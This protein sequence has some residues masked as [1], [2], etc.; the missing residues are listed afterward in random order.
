MYGLFFF[1]QFN[2]DDFDGFI[3]RIDV[4]V[5]GVGQVGGEPI[6]LA[7][8]PGVGLGGAVLLYDFHGAAGERYDH[9]GM[10]VA[11]HGEGRVWKNDGL[12]HSYVVIFE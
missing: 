10:L 1:L 6:G 2:Y 4:G 12:P 5:H 9:A 7:G 8:F 11:V 3:A